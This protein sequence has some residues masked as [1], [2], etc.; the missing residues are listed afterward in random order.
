MALGSTQ[1]DTKFR[2]S[3]MTGDVAQEE[4]LGTATATNAGTET[5]I[6]ALAPSTTP[7]ADNADEA[8][9]SCNE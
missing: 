6:V 1:M 2:F 8:D 3:P 4:A 9:L 7:E 5:T